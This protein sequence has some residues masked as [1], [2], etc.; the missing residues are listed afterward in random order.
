MDYLQSYRLIILTSL[1]VSTV[2]WLCYRANLTADL[3]V[4]K[5]MLPFHDFE[6]LTKTNY[7]Y[8]G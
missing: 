1:A 3:V 4:A 2:I 5:K 8:T 6:S 7:R